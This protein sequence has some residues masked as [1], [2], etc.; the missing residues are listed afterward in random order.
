MKHV[1]FAL[2]KTSVFRAQKSSDEH[3][4]QQSSILQEWNWTF[5]SFC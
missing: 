2:I 5:D 3:I 1:N 4:K